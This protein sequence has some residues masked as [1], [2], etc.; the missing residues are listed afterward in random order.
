MKPNSVPR[1][2]GEHITLWTLALATKIRR[3]K[4]TK[5]REKV[6]LY[7]YFVTEERSPQQ[8]TNLLYYNVVTWLCEESS[9]LLHRL[10]F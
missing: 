9:V 4:L 8:A 1:G 3:Y 6:R 5:L 2:G 7:A 10:F